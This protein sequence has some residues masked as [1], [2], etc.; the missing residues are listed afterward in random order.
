[1]TDLILKIDWRLLFQ[2][3]AVTNDRLFWDLLTDEKT[4]E[5]QGTKWRRD[6]L[7]QVFHHI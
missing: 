1:M 3:R 5:L 4:I 6:M 7:F 2:D